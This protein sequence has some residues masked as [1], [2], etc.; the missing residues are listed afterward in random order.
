M[1]GKDFFAVVERKAQRDFTPEKLSDIE[2]ELDEGTEAMLYGLVAVL[3]GHDGINALNDDLEVAETVSVASDHYMNDATFSDGVSD[4]LM[5]FLSI[6]RDKH[7]VAQKSVYESLDAGDIDAALFRARHGLCHVSASMLSDAAK[8]AGAQDSRLRSGKLKHSSIVKGA[9]AK[10]TNLLVD[11]L[12]EYVTP[13]EVKWQSEGSGVGDPEFVVSSGRNKDVSRPEWMKEPDLDMSGSIQQMIGA[14]LLEYD[15][16]LSLLQWVKLRKLPYL[17]V[18]AP[19]KV[20]GGYDEFESSNSDILLCGIHQNDIVPIQVKNRVGARTAERY[21]P[22]M[23]FIDHNDL[24][25]AEFGAETI[26]GDDGRSRKVRTTTIN[27][28]SI[29]DKTLR[30]MASNNKPGRKKMMIYDTAFKRFDHKIL[31]QLIK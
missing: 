6:D 19:K 10:C 8:T 5:S 11:A 22:E 16:Y 24:G 3:Y 13:I 25:I 30:M 4:A 9:I 31:P 1:D 29:A 28:G 21:I 26:V 15:A 7:S 17:P 23:L 2:I 18:V 12:G 27:Y 20:E 14:G